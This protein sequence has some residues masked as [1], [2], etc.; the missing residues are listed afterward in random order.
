MSLYKDVYQLFDENDCVIIPGFGGF[1][2]NYFEAKIDLRNQ[3]FYP[4]S[5]KI[6]FNENLKN[7]DGILINYISINKSISWDAAERTINAFVNDIKKR[8]NKGEVVKFDKLGQF[9]EKMGVLSFQSNS[10]LNMLEAS[11]GLTSFNFPMIKSAK[12]EIEIQPTP[13][14]STTKS[15]KSNNPTKTTKTRKA[16]MYT[17]STVAAV[18]ALF[19][20]SLYFGIFDFN[21]D[22]NVNYT[23]VVPI[24]II[25]PKTCESGVKTEELTEIAD[26]EILEEQ[27]VIEELNVTEKIIKTEESELLVTEN[28]IVAELVVPQVKIR[29][30]IIAGSFSSIKNAQIMQ[31]NLQKLGFIPEILTTKSGMYRVT[32]K[33]YSDRNIAISELESLCVTLRNDS[34][35]VLFI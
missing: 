9:S 21:N 14:L 26:T 31:T 4:P 6:V 12:Q 2:A 7:N 16:L 3:E 25:K 23:N 27:S 30:Y 34:L 32:V 13:I 1:I 10:D 33:G 28:P 5:R 22:N 17:V 20:V 19:F 35:W 18:F 11:F 29:A 8:L 24:D 15:A